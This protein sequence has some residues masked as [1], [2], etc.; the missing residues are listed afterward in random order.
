ME[1]IPGYDIWKTALPD[2]PEIVQCCK[3]GDDTYKVDLLRTVDGYC[4]K[5]V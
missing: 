2:E 5:T 4:A 1:R 3:C